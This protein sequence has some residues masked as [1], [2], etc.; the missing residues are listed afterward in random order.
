MISWSSKKQPTIARSSTKAEYKAL[1]H[2][3]CELLWL[4]SLFSEL[5]LFLSQPLILHCDSLG[6]TYLSVNPVMH[7]HTKDVDIDY[8]FV[9]D[10][11][12]AKAL[13]VSFVSSKDQ[14]A[15]IFT[16]PLASS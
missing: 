9:H 3:T 8:H 15:D 14:L 10:R 5:G 1:A 13:Q 7:S 6:A 4:Q 12:H 2:A 11:V 16:K